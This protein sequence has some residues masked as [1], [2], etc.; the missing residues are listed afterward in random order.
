MMTFLVSF[1]TATNT[2]SNSSAEGKSEQ[3][4]QMVELEVAKFSKNLP[5]ME[6]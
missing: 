4:D 1:K 3:S 2:F 6:A 5:K